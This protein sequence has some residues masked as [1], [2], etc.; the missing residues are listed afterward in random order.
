MSGS[1]GGGSG[2]RIRLGIASSSATQAIAPAASLA[3]F[4]QRMRGRAPIAPYN[5]GGCD[6]APEPL[7]QANAPL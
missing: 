2:R 5:P 7:A 6:L 3:T 1:S 4:R